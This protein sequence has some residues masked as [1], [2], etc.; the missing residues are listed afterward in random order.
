MR[1]CSKAVLSECTACS[2]R[3]G[4]GECSSRQEISFQQSVQQEPE[5]RREPQGWEERA[6]EEKVHTV[7][8]LPQ[9]YYGR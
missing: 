8:A 5:V 3:H 2:C 4:E 6:E 9:L 1:A 7:P